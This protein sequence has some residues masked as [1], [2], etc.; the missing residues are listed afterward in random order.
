MFTA[1]SA[2]L[3]MR[4]VQ[5]CVFTIPLQL[6]AVGQS[7]AHA[8][9]RHGWLQGFHAST[10]L[11]VAIQVGG[12]LL[13][14]VVI[15]HAGNVLKTFATVL[16]LILTFGLSTVLFDFSPTPLFGAGVLATAL[17]I[18]LYA[19]PDDVSEALERAAALVCGATRGGSDHSAPPSQEVSPVVRQGSSPV[20]SA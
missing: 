10:W 6:L 3:W 2:S 11:V 14:A 9:R 13:T 20:D 8:I 12:A 19:R 16:A 4:N 7:D 5:L 15:K 17:S 1:G 18:Y